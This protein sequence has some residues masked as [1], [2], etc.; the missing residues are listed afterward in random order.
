[1]SWTAASSS[2]RLFTSTFGQNHV[3]P[4]SVFGLLKGKQVALPY[5]CN[6]KHNGVSN[7]EAVE[8]IPLKTRVTVSLFWVIGTTGPHTSLGKSGTYPVIQIHSFY[9]CPGN[10]GALVRSAAPLGNHL[11]VLTNHQLWAFGF[12]YLHLPTTVLLCDRISAF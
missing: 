3:F 9:T 12:L 10:L 4:C 8:D 7:G 1:M 5:Y 6:W 11:V 2:N